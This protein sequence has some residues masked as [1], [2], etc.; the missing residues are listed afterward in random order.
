[1]DL[2]SVSSPSQNDGNGSAMNDPRSTEVKSKDIDK[3]E[4]NLRWGW[5]GLRCSCLQLLNSAPWLCAIISS[6]MFIQGMV[7]SGF[8][9]GT[10]TTIEKRFEL[11]STSAGVIIA[12]YDAAVAL[13]VLFVSYY[14]DYGNKPRILGSG[15]LLFGI[16]CFVWMLPQ[17]TAPPYNYGSITPGDET[18]GA[19]S[20]VTCQGED[21]SSLS[22]YFYVF[23]CAQV[24]LGIGASP[25]YTVGVSFVD[26]SVTT[27]QSG[28][29]LGTIYFFSI[30]GPACGF[31]LGGAFLTIYHD[32]L[33]TDSVTITPQHPAWI[34]AWWLGFFMCMILIWFVAIP[35]SGFPRELPGVKK[36][37]AEKESETHD[38][39]SQLLSKKPGFG[40]SFRDLP[41]AFLMLWKNPTYIFITITAIAEG[42]LIG[43]FTYFMPKFVENQ[44]GVTSALSATLVGVAVVPGAAGGTFVGGWLIKKF[45]LTVQGMIKY[46][47]ILSVL[48]LILGPFFLL[49]CPEPPLAGVHRPYELSYDNDLESVNLTHTCNAG[50]H[51]SLEVYSPVCSN[52]RVYFDP[53]HAGCT[54]YSEKEQM[55]Y[56]CQCI[57]A[58][59]C[60]I[61][62]SVHEYGCVSEEMCNND[63]WTLPIFLTLFFL[64][65]F[66]QFQLTVPGTA[67]TLRCVPDKQRSFAMGMQSVCL[68]ALGT[69]PGP[70]I[71]G[72]V[73]DSTCLL[74]QESCDQTGSC[75]LYDSFQL[76]LRFL[77]LHVVYVTCS[78]IFFALALVVYKPPRS[79]K[80]VYDKEVDIR[81]EESVT[82]GGRENSGSV[83]ALGNT[84]HRNGSNVSLTNISR[85]DSR[86][87]LVDHEAA[88]G[89]TMTMTEKDE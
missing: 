58:K 30:L 79:T 40:M 19:N 70:I 39:K 15:G 67:I 53:C 22:N 59:N 3:D 6:Y 60:T 24:L 33:A 62:G 20:T 8:V 4:D 66:F 72:A 28:V 12:A 13:C 21:W 49:R 57:P 48:A 17:L 64:A 55:Y 82:S 86:G 52:D 31:L 10:L 29:Y 56:D 65:M 38:S 34:G 36:I 1:M 32:L 18:C 84:K 46:S 23:V 74:W 89:K 68:R 76:G 63:C 9:S 42:L 47:I 35:M 85:E 73:V 2:D 16:G 27:K 11:T 50:C 26:E 7:V 71:V 88:V 5:W 51:C 43:G 69:I 25:F 75:W 54:K 37:R 80:Y 78:I 14:G 81:D 41:A 61:E 77:I 87:N 83:P 44:F 45:D